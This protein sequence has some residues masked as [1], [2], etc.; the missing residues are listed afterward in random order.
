MIFIPSIRYTIYI[1]TSVFLPLLLFF[2]L[3]FCIYLFV[4]L[5]LLNFLR[6]ILLV[7]INFHFGQLCFMNLLPN[8]DTFSFPMQVLGSSHIHIKLNKTK[9][10]LKVSSKRGFFVRV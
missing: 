7:N 4:F 9:I 2:I 6:G 3:L 1:S 5:P 8:V 10:Y